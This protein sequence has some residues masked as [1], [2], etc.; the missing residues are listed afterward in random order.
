MEEKKPMNKAH[1]ILHIHVVIIHLHLRDGIENH[2]FS[3]LQKHAFAIFFQWGSV[4]GVKQ[5]NHI[6][7]VFVLIQYISVPQNRDVSEL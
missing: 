5:E 6:H 3:L 4:F 7:G 1:S 2:R